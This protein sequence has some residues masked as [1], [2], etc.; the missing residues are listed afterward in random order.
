MS[1]ELPTT[2]SK[3]L[4]VNTQK[5]YS[6]YLN[7]IAE[8]GFDTVGLLTRYSRRVCNIIK[9]IE[10]GEDEKSK[11]KRRVF[12]SAV[13]WVVSP[14]YKKKINPYSKL[15]DISLPEVFAPR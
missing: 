1:F 10:P 12:V 9:S 2:F 11:W 14:K 13:F 5:I 7:K 8:Y 4:S 15:Y 6:G 3:T